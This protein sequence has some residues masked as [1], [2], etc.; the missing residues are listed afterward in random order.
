ME[1]S[2]LWDAAIV[3]A[4]ILVIA[5]GAWYAR[6]AFRVVDHVDK[7]DQHINYLET[8]RDS[9]VARNQIVEDSLVTVKDEYDSLQT[10][11]G[12]LKVEKA[13]VENEFSKLRQREVYYQKKLKLMERAPLPR[14]DRTTLG[15]QPKQ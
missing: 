10:E 2:K 9:V 14:L 13:E 12:H 7:G 4:V 15:E 3:L 6:T 8:T 11:H 1:N 5:F